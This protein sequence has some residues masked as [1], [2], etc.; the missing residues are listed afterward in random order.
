MTRR[1][2]GCRPNTPQEDATRDA[3]NRAGDLATF[4]Y[5]EDAVEASRA[6][7]YGRSYPQYMGYLDLWTVATHPKRNPCG[8][9]RYLRT[10][11]T[12]RDALHDGPMLP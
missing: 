9:P 7:P 5:R 10:D 12:S 11:G 1:P 3:E 2:I 6:V 8:N 4:T